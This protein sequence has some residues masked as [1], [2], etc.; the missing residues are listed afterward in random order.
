VYRVQAAGQVFVLKV[1]PLAPLADFERT[2]GQLRLAADAGLAPSIVH[3]DA[4]RRAVVTAFVVDRS[5]PAFY[6]SPQ[7]RPT[8]LA[9]LGRTLRRVHDLPAPEAPSKTPQE[10]LG[11]LW[12][13][14]S[15]GGSLPEFVHDAVCRVREQ[16][17][18]APERAPV[19]SHND[20]N[21]TNL[22]FDGERLFLLDWD[23]SGQNDPFFDLATISVFLRMEA[24]DCRALIAAHDGAPFSALPARFS[25][26]QRL[27]AALCGAMFLQLARGAGHAGANGET[28]ASSPSLGDVYQRARSGAVSFASPGGQWEFGLALIKASAEL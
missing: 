20:V 21:P 1:S 22:A 19:L 13:G 27:A 28:L 9:L 17:A 23:T 10:F 6:F 8:A 5:F 3:V 4:A 25:Y 2:L 7:T 12:S 26:N 15:A 14:L 11:E 24:D 16:P 18:P